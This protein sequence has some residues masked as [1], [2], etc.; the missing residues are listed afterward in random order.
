MAIALCT[1]VSLAHT[2]Y[3]AHRSGGLDRDRRVCDGEWSE[4]KIRGNG[5]RQWLQSAGLRSSLDGGKS[6]CLRRGGTSITI[7]VNR[8]RRGTHTL[9]ALK[10]NG[11]VALSHV[12]FAPPL[13]VIEQFDSQGCQQQNK[14]S[15]NECT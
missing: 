10:E 7:G 12:I 8:T 3:L 15:G 4:R 5:R 6:V 11:L 9:G 2:I 14:N 13:F 1:S